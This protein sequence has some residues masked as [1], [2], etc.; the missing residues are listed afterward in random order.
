MH[1]GQIIK[2][3]RDSFVKIK[4]ILW[5]W[6]YKAFSSSLNFGDTCNFNFLFRDMG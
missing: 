1:D 2:R 6:R 3:I 4:S 5:I